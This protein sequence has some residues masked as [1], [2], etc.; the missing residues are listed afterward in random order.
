VDRHG[1]PSPINRYRHKDGHEVITESTGE[2]IFDKEGKLIKWQGMDR[3]I[4][5]RKRFEDALQQV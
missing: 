4:T 5:A 1:A 3:D 2:S